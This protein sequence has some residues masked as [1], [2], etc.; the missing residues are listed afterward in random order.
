MLEKK[1]VKLSAECNFLRTRVEEIE[2]RGPSNENNTNAR[3]Y[4]KL[5]NRLKVLEDENNARKE[6]ELK[7]EITNWM[8]LT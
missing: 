1:I 8:T 3:A 6:K 4:D 5:L 7:L 2:R